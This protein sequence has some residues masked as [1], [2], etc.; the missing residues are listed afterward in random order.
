M[1]VPALA[2]DGPFGLE[3]DHSNAPVLAR[4]PRGRHGLPQDFIDRNHRNRLLAGALE[5]VAERG[6]PAMTVADITSHA[7]VSRGAFYR[8]FSDK[9]DCF[10]A[11]YE[12][13]AD[14]LYETVAAA[15]EPGRDWAVSVAWAIRRALDLLAADPRLA[16]VCTV[17]VFVVGPAAVRQH[18]ALIERLASQLRR[19]REESVVALPP[20]LEEA[21][22]GGAVS[23]IARYVHAGR[24]G[25]LAELGPV[26]VELFLNPYLGIDESRRMLAVG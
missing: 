12:V 3:V 4:L 16:G 10:L 18:E 5:A 13:A 22:L 23:L 2:T 6:Y 8:H 15:V 9:E 19:G 17:E 14:W 24:A 1:A 7:A 25:H 11:A 26:L 21:L 20:Q